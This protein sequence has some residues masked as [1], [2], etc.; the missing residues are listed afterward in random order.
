MK[1]LLIAAVF[2]CG[3]ATTGFAQAEY[4]NDDA[5]KTTGGIWTEVGVTKV[6]PYNLSLGLDAGFR[7][8]EWFNE[9]NRFDI[10]LGLS[11]KPNKHWKF[12]I[13]YTFLM[14]HYPA[15][16]EYKTEYKYRPNGAS[17]NVDFIEF[18]GGPTYDDG[19]TTYKYKG[20]NVTTR[21]TDT[22]WRAR[23][24]ISIDA[25]YTI[26]FW[27]WLR[28]SLRERYQLTFVPTKTVSRE[29]TIDKYRDMSYAQSPA[30]SEADV[31]YDELMRY[32]QEGETIY[33]LDLLDDNASPTNVTS[34]Y[35]TEHE[36]LNPEKEKDSKTLHLLR[37]RLTL[38]VD[39]KGWNW[40]PYCYFEAFNN[41]GER[42]HFDKYRISAGVDYAFQN[43]H[44]LGIGYVFNH[45][46]DD[47][48]DM[49]IHAIT[50]GY[51]FKF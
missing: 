44:K 16:T 41:I 14:K 38:E 40:S 34:S 24:R 27:K 25:A 20:K 26:K 4:V 45:E 7:T 10:G 3:M 28:L 21:S 2:L 5:G 13:G 32:W 18:L 19:T 47:D 49:N 35:L 23:H 9:A 39:K 30:T 1:R 12:G 43:G 46:N 36:T 31:T 42:M 17:E 37:S 51:K 50:I 6:L 48:G 29:K 15:V 33:E 8:N 22:Y 11:W